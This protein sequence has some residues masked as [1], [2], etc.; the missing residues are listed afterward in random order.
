[1]KKIIALIAAHM[2][3]SSSMA[4]DGA[5][6]LE[7][8]MPVKD[9]LVAGNSKAAATAAGTLHARVAAAPDFTGKAG[10]VASLE[11]VEHAASLEKQRAAF[12]ELSAGMWTVIKKKPV[13]GHAVYYQYCPMKKAYWI[14][15][16]PAIK[17]PYY[18]AAMLTCGRVAE[19]NKK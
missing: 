7:G 10:L 8:Y 17:N 16:E 5:K 3:V 13:S 18:G 14:S 4:Q 6:L 9:A 12:Q 15:D 11:K 2:V 1:M 19:T